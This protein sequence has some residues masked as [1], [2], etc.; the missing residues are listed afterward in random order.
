M[1]GM[2]LYTYLCKISLKGLF[3][4]QA[5]LTVCCPDLGD[6]THEKPTL[7][8]IL[9]GLYVKNLTEVKGTTLM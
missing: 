9:G 6:L 1:T 8:K 3:I 2:W 4:H 7:G 5:L